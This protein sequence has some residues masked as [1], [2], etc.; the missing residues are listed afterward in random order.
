MVDEMVTDQ[1]DIKYYFT[2]YMNRA[3]NARKKSLNIKKYN[4]AM[5]FT[6]CAYIAL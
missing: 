5:D 3:N 6:M 2:L 4:K 1:V